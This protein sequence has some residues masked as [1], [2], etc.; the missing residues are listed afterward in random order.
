MTVLLVV[1]GLVTFWAKSEHSRA[2]ERFP[3]CSSDCTD[4][5]ELRSLAM[6]KMDLYNTLVVDNK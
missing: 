1:V 5:T 4:S 6:Y 3:V 2:S